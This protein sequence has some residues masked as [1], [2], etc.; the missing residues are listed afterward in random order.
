MTNPLYPNFSKSLDLKR[1]IEEFPPNPKLYINAKFIDRKIVKIED[2]AKPAYFQIRKNGTDESNK[3]AIKQSILNNGFL[4][5]TRP[6]FGWYVENSPIIKLGDGITRCTGMSELGFTHFLIDII[7]PES[8]L[9]IAKNSLAANINPKPRKAATID[10]FVSAITFQIGERNLR[11][12]EKSIRDFLNDIPNVNS[13]TKSRVLID[14]MNLNGTPSK[15]SSYITRGGN[16]I[17]S[18]SNSKSN[19][20]IGVNNVDKAAEILGIPYGGK[21]KDGF[22]GY[23]T[24][25]GGGSRMTL[26]NMMKKLVEKDCDKVYI[27][28]YIQ[29]PKGT[30]FKL[31]KDRQAWLD[32]FNSNILVIRKFIARSAKTELSSIESPFVF[33][34]FYPQDLSRDPSNGGNPV[35]TH[36]SIVNVNGDD[37]DWKTYK[38]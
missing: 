11:N 21:E 26:L 29:N 6:P 23:V 33:G 2:I 14:V 22:V 32:S 5:D 38:F 36:R 1:S 24:G 4:Y 3:S 27:F 31:R 20:V 8:P 34:G 7:E 10:D 18:K 12:D 19:S 37:I 13:E 16:F 9:E 30:S 15:F 35:E 25:E 28:A 17:V